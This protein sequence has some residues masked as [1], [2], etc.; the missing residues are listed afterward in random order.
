MAVSTPH[1]YPVRLSEEQRE[2]LHQIASCGRAPARKV[3]HAQVLLASDRN[4]PGGKLTRD[5]IA[6][7]LHMH[8]NTVD[9]I[10]KRFAQEGEAPALDRRPRPPERAT[11]PRLDGRAEA[12]LV[13]MCC[14]GPPPGRTRWTLRL[15]ADELSRRRVVTSVCAETVRKTLKKTRCSPGGSAAG[16]SRSATRP[17]SWPRWRTCWTRTPSRATPTS[18]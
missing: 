17:G 6:L 10:R 4:R 9:R 18:R 8:V 15:L 13:A 1:L 2:R 5:A 11:P 12:H 7:A 16:A 14:S 3:R